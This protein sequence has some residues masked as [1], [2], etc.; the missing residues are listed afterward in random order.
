MIYDIPKKLKEEYK[1]FHKP[2]IYLKDVEAGCVF[3][4]M[5]YFFKGWVHSWVLLPY[6][7]IAAAM[8][9]FLIQPSRSNPGKRNWEAILLF[10]GRDQTTYRS[11]NHDQ[12]GAEP[13]DE[14]R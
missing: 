8:I 3:L 7:I 13:D 1:I 12:E 10:L 2:D 11:I 9:F 5:F 6:W 14:Q 4:G